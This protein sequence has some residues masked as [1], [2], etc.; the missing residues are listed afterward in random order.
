MQFVHRH[1][2]VVIPPISI[3]NATSPLD[4]PLTL[5]L[6]LDLSCWFLERIYAMYSRKLFIMLWVASIQ[7]NPPMIENAPSSEIF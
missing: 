1:L 5:D 3:Q 4:G 2:Q 6:N 7:E